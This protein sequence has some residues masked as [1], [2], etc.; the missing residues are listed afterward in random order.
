[1]I[2]GTKTSWAAGPLGEWDLP[3]VNFV[4]EGQTE[5]TFVRDVLAEY[6]APRGVY[7]RARCVETSRTRA[8]VFRGGMTTYLRAKRDIQR[9]LSEDQGAYLTTMFDLYRLPDDFPNRPAASRIVDPLAKAEFI[10]RGIAEDIGHRS[11]LPYIQVHEF[12][13]LLFCAPQITDRTL[14]ATPHASKLEELQQ[15][16]NTF[17]TPEHI[18]EGVESAPSKRLIQLY[19]SYRKPVFGPL[20][21]Q[22]TGMVVLRESCR[23]FS[24][25]MERLETLR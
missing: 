12:E 19:E 14:A 15:I 7:A 1:V 17:L 6:L 25:W 16:R 3:R 21:T 8:W 22:R 23:H 5:E 20:I 18:N 4:V 11:F 9:W 10:E 2:C 24:Q 13:S